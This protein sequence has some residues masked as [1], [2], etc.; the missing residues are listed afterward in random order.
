MTGWRVGAST[1]CVVQESTVYSVWPFHH[2][3]H[4]QNFSGPPMHIIPS[5]HPASGL[6]CLLSINTMVLLLWEFYINGIIKS[7]VFCVWLPSLRM[8]LRN[9]HIVARINNLFPFITEYY[10]IEWV[11]YNLSICKLK[12]IWVLSRFDH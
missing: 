6:L 9:I 1:L 10:S 11:L 12:D 3:H 8:L 4:L 2:L 5:P 7:V